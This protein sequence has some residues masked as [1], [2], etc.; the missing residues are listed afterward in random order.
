M[1]FKPYAPTP[2]SVYSHAM[3]LARPT[4]C[5]LVAALLVSGPLVFAED[6][7]SPTV[8]PAVPPASPA[9]P[10]IAPPT[11]TPAPP[12]PA[13]QAVL[14]RIEAASQ[15]V[16]TLE[17]RL[18][19]SV[20]QG[21]LGSEQVRYGLLR[22]AASTPAGGNSPAQPQRFHLDFDGLVV[23]GKKQALSQHWIYDGYWLL[24]LNDK[25][26]AG[27]RR[28]LVPANTPATQVAA[29]TKQGI[30]LPLVMPFHQATLLSLYR[31]T[32]IQDVQI[33]GAKE[34]GPI[35][36]VRLSLAPLPGNKTTL[37]AL[38]LDFRA[39]TFLPLA[40]QFSE[41]DDST[42]IRLSKPVANP[43]LPA[44]C[45]D[46]TPPAD[47]QWKV[48]VIPLATAPLGL[49]PAIPAANPRPQTPA[50]APA[51]PVAPIAKP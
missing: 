10:P 21:L 18:R 34:E 31:L 26:H 8:A 13:Q 48:D 16:L 5:L 41:N 3:P 19:Y 47:A 6:T 1:G 44:D 39:D 15:K 36:A 29:G 4:P 9:T 12:T 24:E 45:F 28:E 50:T 49:P 30:V 17:S 33:A 2:Q 37:T 46:T 22:A 25:D 32:D 20:A 23:D 7:A 14:D 38:Q 35:N 11:P 43:T 42:E 51:T 27:T 40:L